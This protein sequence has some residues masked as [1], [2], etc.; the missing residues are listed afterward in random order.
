MCVETSRRRELAEIPS[1]YRRFGSGPKAPLPRTST[2]GV[3]L[4]A[5]PTGCIS[6]FIEARIMK[7]SRRQFL[8]L[9]GGLL[10]NE[11]EALQAKVP[12]KDAPRTA[13]EGRSQLNRMARDAAGTNWLAKWFPSV[14]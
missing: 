8:H 4:R 10:R 6:K 9:A 1:A 5:D 7:C 13:W 3:V 2:I 14:G 12:T 11:A